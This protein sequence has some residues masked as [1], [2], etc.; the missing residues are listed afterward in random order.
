MACNGV[1]VLSSGND[2][3]DPFTQLGSALYPALALA[4][5]ACR[6]NAI[7]LFQR[8]GAILR[9]IKDI[10]PGEEVWY[11]HVHYPCT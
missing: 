8:S 9:A 5:H 3:T 6:P 11:E 4:N 7:V 2:T 10:S 1:A